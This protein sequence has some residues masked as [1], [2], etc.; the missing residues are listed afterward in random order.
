MEIWVITERSCSQPFINL[1]IYS[2]DLVKD[3]V[4]PPLMYI[5]VYDGIFNGKFSPAKG[6]IV[7]GV[8]ALIGP[9]LLDNVLDRDEI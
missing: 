3:Q 6:D 1:R 8:L 2:S 4:Y 7:F 9:P 5:E